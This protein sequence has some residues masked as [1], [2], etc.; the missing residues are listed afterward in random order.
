MSRRFCVLS[1]FVFFSL[2]IG[3]AEGAIVGQ[4]VAD[5]LSIGAVTSWNVSSG[6][7]W[8]DRRRRPR[9]CRV[10]LRI[11]PFVST[12]TISSPSPRDIRWSV[13]VTSRSRPSSRL[14]SAEPG[15]WGYDWWNSSGIVSMELGGADRG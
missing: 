6:L 14:R 5:D 15:G 9:G 1:S 2:L 4:W 11:K 8:R 3:F 7:I 10:W 13:W 12:V